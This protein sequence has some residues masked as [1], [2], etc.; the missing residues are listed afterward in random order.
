MIAENPPRTDPTATQE[1]IPKTFSRV[2]FLWLTA[3]GYWSQKAKLPR[4]V[5]P[6]KAMIAQCLRVIFL[7]S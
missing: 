6:R 2:V 5:I 7:F 3:W 1:K 4:V